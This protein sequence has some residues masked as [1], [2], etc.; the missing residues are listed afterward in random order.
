[1]IDPNV[2][3]PLP[4]SIVPQKVRRADGTPAELITPRQ[5]AILVGRKVST[6]DRWIAEGRVLITMTPDH[7]RRIF[8]DSLWM[9]LPLELRR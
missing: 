8:V 9:A 1:M 7:E 2:P 3:A 6:I 5:A 4:P